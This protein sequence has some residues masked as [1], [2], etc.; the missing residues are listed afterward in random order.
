[1]FMNNKLIASVVFASTLVAAAAA[2]LGGA[3]A[4]TVF[5]DNFNSDPQGLNSTPAGWTL[6]VGPV[7]VIGV[8]GPYDYY[9]G[10]GTYVDLNGSPGYGGLATIQIF[11]PGTYKVGFNLGSSVGGAGHVD[12]ASTPKLTQVCLGNAA[13]TTI[14]LPSLPAV[15]TSNLLTF[16]T[17]VAGTLS[18]TSLPD[19]NIGSPYNVDV[20]NILDNVQVSN[21]PLPS[22]WLM[23]LGGLAGLGFFA[24]R[25]TKKN[26]AALAAA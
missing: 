18:F 13:C 11:A 1:M 8:G 15:W 14:S 26:S 22:T 23:L 7:D 5:F 21:N 12:A 4:S 6:T 17:T 24:Y 16:T 9:P 10:N 3:Q 25:G 19:P 20:G 2:P